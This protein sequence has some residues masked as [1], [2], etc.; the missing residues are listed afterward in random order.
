M[1]EMVPVTR[2]VLGIE[3][4]SAGRLVA[5]SVEIEVDEIAI[6]LQGARVM[7]TR[8]RTLGVAPPSYRGPT[9]ASVPAVLLPRS[10]RRQSPALSLTNYQDNAAR[11]IQ[12][13][14]T[15]NRRR[16]NVSR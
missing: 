12:R 3:R 8:P 13:R 11:R 5:S 7:R 10:S 1:S 6:V 2:T 9:G 16:P 14:Y 4:A 15:S